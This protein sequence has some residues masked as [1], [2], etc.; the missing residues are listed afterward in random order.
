MRCIIWTVHILRLLFISRDTNF[1]EKKVVFN[2][3]NWT[4]L[5]CHL[6][7]YQQTIYKR[8]TTPKQRIKS[9][10][11]K[12]GMLRLVMLLI[13][14]VFGNNGFLKKRWAE[15]NLKKYIWAELWKILLSW[16][17]WVS[18]KLSWNWAKLNWPN[19]RAFSL[20]ADKYLVLKSTS[21][22]IM[23]FCRLFKSLF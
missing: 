3:V 14:D 7:S 18:K 13:V 22:K 5:R 4:R 16:A 2:Q 8:R 20:W 23:N 19:F 1:I 12:T 6:E 11:G 10:R 15:R 17:E 9:E 21:V